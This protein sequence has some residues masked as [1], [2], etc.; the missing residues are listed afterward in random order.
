MLDSNVAN[1]ASDMMVDISGKTGALA[2]F[3]GSD[4]INT[5]PT[6]GDRIHDAKM[7]AMHSTPY[8]EALK[9]NEI[10]FFKPSE[11]GIELAKYKGMGVILDDNLVTTTA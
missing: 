3:N 8:S 10:T 4:V 2:T 7:I 5:A 11:N 6:L 1:N 9:N